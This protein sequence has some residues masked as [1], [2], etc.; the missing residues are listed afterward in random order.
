MMT[1]SFVAQVRS[2]C[3]VP[4]AATTAGI[5]LKKSRREIIEF[6]NPQTTTEC[7]RVPAQDQDRPPA[8]LSTVSAG[9]IFIAQD[10]KLSPLLSQNV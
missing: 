2:G 1:S 5:V 10:F 8:K 6:R 3:I 9:S 4:A 7:K